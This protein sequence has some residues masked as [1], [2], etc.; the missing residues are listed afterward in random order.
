M[1]GFIRSMT[2]LACSKVSLP[3][4]LELAPHVQQ[5][6]SAAAAA[7]PVLDARAKTLAVFIG[8][9]G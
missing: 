5:L 3:G 7:T 1:K 6:E 9:E 8:L 4:R 2:L